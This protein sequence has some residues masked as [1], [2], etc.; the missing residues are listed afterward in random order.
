MDKLG[1]VWSPRGH[2]T[3]KLSCY[4]TDYDDDGM[5]NFK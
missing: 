4:Y 2:K 3:Q 5:E 1:C